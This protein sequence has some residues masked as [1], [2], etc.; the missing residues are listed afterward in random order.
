[1]RNKKKNWADSLDE[2]MNRLKYS[3]EQMM[4][5]RKSKS[6]LNITRIN[7]K[8]T[9]DEVNGVFEVD[10]TLTELKQDQEMSSEEEKD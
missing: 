10:E 6:F 1:M 2:R 5:F 9:S 8:D 3:D 4:H 7:F